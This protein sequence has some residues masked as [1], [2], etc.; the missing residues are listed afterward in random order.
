[1][2]IATFYIQKRPLIGGAASYITLTVSMRVLHHS[3]HAYPIRPGLVYYAV[4]AVGATVLAMI[5]FAMSL[6]TGRSKYIAWF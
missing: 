2:W 3:S 6:F 1:M 5:A 4:C